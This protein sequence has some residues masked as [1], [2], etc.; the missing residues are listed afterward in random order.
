MRILV[1]IAI[2]LSAIT[3]AS[4]QIR[5]DAGTSVG[6]TSASASFRDLPGFP[7]CC[8]SFESGSGTGLGLGFGVDIPIAG[9]L[10][11]SVR[12]AVNDRSHT[13]S[14][15][16]L[17]DIIVGNRLVQSTIEHTFA[18]PLTEYGIESHIGYHFG[19]LTLRTGIGYSHRALG[20]VRAKEEIVDPSGV[21]FTE[22]QSTTRNARTAP[23]PGSIT[24]AWHWI[25]VLGFD[26]PLK[27][28][29]A[30][31]LTP[32]A[33]LTTAL[34]SVT[35][36]TPWDLTTTSIGLR[37]S[38]TFGV[39]NQ[40]VLAPNKEPRKLA[41]TPPA[42]AKPIVPSTL[43]PVSYDVKLETDAKLQVRIEE[44]EEETY[45]PVLPYVFFDRYSARVP[46]RYAT[47]SMSSMSTTDMSE[48][49]LHRQVFNVIAERMKL[50]PAAELTLTG[51][52][53]VDEQDT[54]L[55]IKRAM[56]IASVLVDSFGV[57]KR[58]IVTRAR[59]LPLNAT[60]ATGAESAL[61][62]DEN[63]RVEL[64]SN[65]S[66]LLMPYRV[67]DTTL[68]MDPPSITIRA[69]TL[70]GKPLDSWRVSAEGA[71]VDSSSRQG[72]VEFTYQPTQ[73]AAQSAL[74]NAEM[75]I[76]IEGRQSGTM[77][78]DTLRLTVDALRLFDKRRE[79]RNDSIIERFT[80]IVFPF[81]KSELTDAHEQILDFVRSR[82]GENARIIVEGSTDILGS[83]DENAR[84]S[85]ER[86]AAVARELQGAITI[87]GLGEPDAGV[88]QQLPEER[89][90]R[91]V[92][93][94]TAYVPVG[95]K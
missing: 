44:I 40:P 78:R 94:I 4:A 74:A 72:K 29:G 83:S 67:A 64:S 93:T 77:V 70:D 90:L 3:I 11:G 73:A 24:S 79:M 38:Y 1:G 33:S 76:T 18:L 80:L 27:R 65:E 9:T 84:L 6:F 89:M 48:T 58:R 5:V 16:E 30:W 51:T 55:A 17:V 28:G 81:R 61:A 43:Q 68:T 71:N 69:K 22:T 10:F 92:V 82:V 63:R 39:N 26:I 12:F 60:L 32:E 2:V 14:T 53:A 86:A 75:S 31:K 45:L 36:V 88:S 13:M 91:R 41:A 8:P 66:Q 50:Y 21:R 34:T 49:D 59:R 25:G 87:R 62:D 95:G 52:C 20:S 85:R 15:N 35:S 42:A 7:T 19:G 56:S 37:L 46:M 54:S 23:M 57:D 47:R